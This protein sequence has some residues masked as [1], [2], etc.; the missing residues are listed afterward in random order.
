MSEPHRVA[1]IIGTRPEAIKMA[2]VIRAVN[3]RAGLRARVVS[4]G[5]HREMLQQVVELFGIEVDAELDVMRPGQALAG[6]T[7]RLLGGIDAE[8]AA[9]PPA[10]ALVQGDTTTVL[11]ASLAAFYRRIPTGH[12]E[13]GLRSGDL[14]QPFPEEG[15]RLLATRLATLHFPPT[16]VSEANLRREGVPA[17]R[18]TVTGN[19]VIDAL[20]AEVSRQETPGV[21][22]GLDAALA[23]FLPPAALR[24]PYVLITGHRRESFG[25]GFEGIC[26]AVARLA[27]D[28]PEVSFV[29][30]VHLN[31]AVQEPVNRLLAGRPNVFLL[32]PQPYAPFVRLMRGAR[33]LLTDSGGVQEEAPGLGKPVLVMRETT[34]RP[35]GVDAGTVKL[36]GTDA[37][38]IHAEVSELLTDGASFASMSNAINPYGDGHAAGRIADA[39]AAYLRSG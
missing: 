2:P 21:T 38:R 11:A 30:P 37:R 10:F 24:R 19:T 29:Y 39:V 18:I 25:G 15:N 28:H 9:H 12:V 1:C 17:G 31:P 8:F 33:L 4:T 5:Q 22:E 3:A 14:A 7:A 27:A 13:A 36:V 34:E 6:L 26:D 20:H 23:T 35:E 32:P 16:A